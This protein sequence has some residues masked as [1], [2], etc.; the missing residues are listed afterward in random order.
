M[1]LNAILV[2][3]GSVELSGMLGSR[4]GWGGGGGGQ[5]RFAGGPMMVVFGFS[6]P[7]STKKKEEKKETLPKTPS[8]KTFWIPA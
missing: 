7:S 6:L 4:R 1:A 5:R 8:D 3:F 2:S